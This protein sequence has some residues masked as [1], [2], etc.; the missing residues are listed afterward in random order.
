MP[1]T[2]IIEMQ[3]KPAPQSPSTSGTGGYGSS[4]TK[5]ATAVRV[6]MPVV[7]GSTVVI[8]IDK[9]YPADKSNVLDVIAALPLL[10]DAIGLLEKARTAMRTDP[11]TSDQ[12]WQRFQV[13]LPNLFKHR[14]IGDGYGVVINALHFACINLHG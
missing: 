12:Y 5:D 3:P 10:A 7:R 13:L 8:E 4:G 14:K 2:N 11:T 1:E 6:A 9:L